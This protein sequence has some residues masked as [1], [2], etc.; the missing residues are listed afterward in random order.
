MWKLTAFLLL[1]SIAQAAP[2]PAKN[3]LDV[4][5]TS[6]TFQAARTQGS[7]ACQALNKRQYEYK[8]CVMWSAYYR[9]DVN[10]CAPLKKFDEARKQKRG[11]EVRH[12]KCLAM[13]SVLTKNKKLCQMSL[14]QDR[15]L[16]E[17]YARNTPTTM[18]VWGINYWE[19][20]RA[21]TAKP[22][23]K[24]APKKSATKSR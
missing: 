17:K 10:D 21:M 7:A 5:L 12:Y 19:P 22:A 2:P 11:E 15:R 24:P 16:C 4:P 3:G 9:H 18:A 13:V 14:P 20:P 1:T 6:K 8:L 23:P